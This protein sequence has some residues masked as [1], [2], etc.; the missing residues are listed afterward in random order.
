MNPV[1]LESRVRAE[2]L[3][4]D[5]TPEEEQSNDKRIDVRQRSL[6]EI[7]LGFHAMLE[8]A[9]IINC[10]VEDLYYETSK[11]APENCSSGDIEKFSKLLI[12]K[13][14]DRTD[15]FGEGARYYFGAYLRRLIEDSK[16]ERFRIYSGDSLLDDFSVDRMRENVFIHGN[17]GGFLGYQMGGLYSKI[18]VSGN[19]GDCLGYRMSSG[20]IY[21]RGDVNAGDGESGLGYKA[22]GG[23]IKIGGELEGDI[24]DYEDNFDYFAK[25]HEEDLI[26]GRQ[27]GLTVY[28][29]GRLIME[30]GIWQ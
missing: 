29:K 22:T 5:L 7:L 11:H 2:D 20:T 25:D 10:G 16:D 27:C 26:E 23:T 9:E 13:Y 19:A 3:F 24:N 28:H 21:I 14:A 17:V 18:F 8:E 30:D 4:S 15:S 12:D 1:I 6:N